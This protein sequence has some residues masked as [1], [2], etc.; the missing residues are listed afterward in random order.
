[1]KLHGALFTASTAGH[2]TVSVM[3]MIGSVIRRAVSSSRSFNPLIPACGYRAAGNPS[4]TGSSRETARPIRRTLTGSP[5]ARISRPSASLT[6]SSSSTRRRSVRSGRLSRAAFER[7]RESRAQTLCRAVI[8][9]SRQR[10]AKARAPATRPAARSCRAELDDRSAD[11]E[12]YAHAVGLVPKTV[13][14]DAS[15]IPASPRAR[16]RARSPARRHQ[17]R[18][19]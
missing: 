17:R 7:W 8:R 19:R 6:A 10:E 18:P 12:A 1:V 2:I 5:L 13:R 14:T 3:K 11:V 15:P 16:D 4:R 9:N